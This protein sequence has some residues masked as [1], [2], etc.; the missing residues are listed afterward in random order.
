MQSRIESGL[1]KAKSQKLW[2]VSYENL[3][4]KGP[5]GPKWD[6]KMDNFGSQIGSKSGLGAF[7]ESRRA[8]GTPKGHLSDLKWGQTEPPRASQDGQR[9]LKRAPTT[10]K[11]GSE[12]AFYE[13]G[14]QGHFF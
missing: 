9:P 6:P 7:L 3:I 13:L 14:R 4:F 2:D 10:L 12:N 1:K 5:G 8:G 11:R